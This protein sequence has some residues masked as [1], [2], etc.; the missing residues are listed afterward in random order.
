MRVLAAGTFFPVNNSVLKGSVPLGEL[1][2]RM[3]LAADWV[4]LDTAPVTIGALTSTVATSADGVVL[5]VDLSDV[6]RDVL[7]AA[8]DQLRAAG[9]NIIGVVL[10]RAPALL[11][12][13][14]YRAYYESAGVGKDANG[15]GSGSGRRRWLSR[16]GRD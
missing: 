8:A 2:E 14:D 11:G 6:D 15:N 3:R 13:T 9:A 5:V 12:E 1:V 4:V 16:A 10:N 7:V